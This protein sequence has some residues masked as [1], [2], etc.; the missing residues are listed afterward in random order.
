M[1]LHAPGAVRLADDA[2]EQVTQLT[3][4]PDPGINPPSDRPG[5]SVTGAAYA[6]GSRVRIPAAAWRTRRVNATGRRV[7]CKIFKLD[8]PRPGMPDGGCTLSGEEIAEQ[9]NLSPRTIDTQFAALEREGMIE[10]EPRITGDGQLSSVRWAKAPG[11]NFRGLWVDVPV[12]AIDTLKGHEFPVLCELMM[13]LIL[14]KP[15][16]LREIGDAVGLTPA[17]TMEYLERLEERGLVHIHERAGR[18]GRHVFRARWF[19]DQD[20]VGSRPTTQA[21]AEPG[22]A[23]AVD[24]VEAGE[25]HA[26]PG[27][28]RVATEPAQGA[29]HG[30][31]PGRSALSGPT[32]GSVAREDELEAGDVPGQRG[33]KRH[34]A[35]AKGL[36]SPSRPADPKAPVRV[37]LAP[38]LV[39]QMV[40][41]V[42]VHA[43]ADLLERLSTRGRV[44]ALAAKIAEYVL[45]HPEDT[46]ERLAAR[47][48]NAMNRTS[49]TS[50]PDPFGWL[51]TAATRRQGCPDPDCEDGVLWTRD[52]IPCTACRARTVE[53]GIAKN[54]L[55]A[56]T[57]GVPEA[58]RA[59]ERADAGR[60]EGFDQYREQFAALRSRNQ[61]AEK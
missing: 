11:G 9:M 38:E 55:V 6:P 44:R 15:A 34:E 18:G 61:Q 8:R 23:A 26:A 24:I 32:P 47:L 16:S 5:S 33:W 20:F 37:S 58:Y 54:G 1:R 43:G 51:L 39:D 12:G 56:A 36:A 17:R 53:R 59:P 46:P 13:R 29:A 10:S 14:G 2:D 3:D 45:E 7:F 41:Q 28:P 35:A 57:V 21:V 48:R 60:A 22:Q 30:T 4:S 52:K 40:R 42:L 27:D 19:A 31:Q 49:G 50:S 25:A